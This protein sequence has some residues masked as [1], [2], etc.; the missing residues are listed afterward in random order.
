MGI[1]IPITCAMLRARWDMAEGNHWPNHWPG[2]VRVV[3][4]RRNALTNMVGPGGLEPPTRP[5]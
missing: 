4:F 3:R 1:I 2:I 5:L